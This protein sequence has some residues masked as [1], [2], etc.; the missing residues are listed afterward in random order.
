MTKILQISDTHLV[1][2]GGF[3]SGCLDTTNPLKRLTVRIS[4]LQLEVGS[5]DAIIVSGDISDDDTPESYERFK[6]ILSSLKLPIY[7]VSGNHDER[8]PFRDAFFDAN[9]LPKLGKLNWQQ[10]VGQLQIISLD[11]L[12]EGQGGGELDSDTLDF[13]ETCLK[14]LKN[15]P[16]VLM[17]HHPPFKSGIEFMDS[18][19][20]HIGVQRLSEI[21]ANYAGKLLVVCGHIHHNIFTQLAGHAVILAPSVCRSFFIQCPQKCSSWLFEIRRRG[22][23]SSLGWGG[24]INSN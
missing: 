18:I 2:K 5:L 1:K 9:Y 7:C 11:T 10:A 20:L 15:T 6:S 14:E 3:V 22:F 24:K 21:L 4:E 13:L 17:F 19:G 12:I 8:M 23:T 16:V